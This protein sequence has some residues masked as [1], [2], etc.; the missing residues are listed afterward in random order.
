MLSSLNFDCPLFHIHDIDIEK[1]EKKSLQVKLINL[2][3][4]KIKLVH[5]S[6]QLSMNAKY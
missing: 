4:P 6:F 5:G 2:K 1:G 3:A